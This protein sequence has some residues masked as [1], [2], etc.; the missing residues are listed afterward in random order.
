[1]RYLFCIHVTLEVPMALDD[2]V[3]A[4]KVHDGDLI[5]LTDSGAGLAMGCVAIEWNVK[6]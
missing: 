5:M 4:G 1:M 2:S 6:G 3:R